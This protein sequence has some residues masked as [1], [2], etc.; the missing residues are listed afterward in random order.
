MVAFIGLNNHV[1]NYTFIEAPH[2]NI[3]P[4]IMSISDDV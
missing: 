1:G 4:F 2:N 3:I